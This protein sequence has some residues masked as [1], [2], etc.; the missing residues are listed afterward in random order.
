MPRVSVI[1]PSYNHEKYVAEAIQSVLDQTFEDFE[2]VITD[3]GSSDRTVD[4]IEGFKDK[5][6][7]LFT[8]EENQGACVAARK[9][10][11]EA[12][13]EYVAMLSSDDVFLPGKLEKQVKFLDEHPEIY[14]VFGYARIID[15]DGAD[16]NDENHFYSSIFRQPNRTRHEWLRHFF[17]HGNCLCHPSALICRKLYDEIGCYDERFHQLPDFDFWVRTCLR[18]DIHVLPEELIKFRVRAGEANVSGNRPVVMRRAYFE[19]SRIYRHY[20]EIDSVKEFLKIFP[21]AK[22]RWEGMEDGL[23][24]FYLAM[25]AVEIESFYPVHQRL[26]VDTLFDLLGDR[27]KL[28][29]LDKKHGFRHRDFIKLTGKYDAAG[30]ETGLLR[31]QV[32]EY[33]RQV[34]ELKNSM[35]WKVTAPLRSILELLKSS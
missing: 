1:I 35:S 21:E 3:D 22:D 8:F 6:I 13:G 20:L 29:R 34:E 14:A 32:D 18:H 12:S 26:A 4:V 16:F 25:V 23:I 2:I 27:E 5:R 11:D 15:E 33:K 31:Q 10:L 7:R 30:Y 28:E 17:F 19:F 24:S 9:C